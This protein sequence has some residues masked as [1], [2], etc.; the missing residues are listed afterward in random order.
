LVFSVHLAGQLDLAMT[1]LIFAGGYRVC[2]GVFAVHFAGQLDSA[3]TALFAAGV[4]VLE[5]DSAMPAF[6]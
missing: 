1:V 2:L 3:K 6:S 4:L 5:L